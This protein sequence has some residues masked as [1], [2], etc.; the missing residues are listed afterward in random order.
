MIET[1]GVNNEDHVWLGID[2]GVTTGWALV[3]DDGKVLG[4][5]DLVPENIEFGLDKIVRGLHRTSRTITVVIERI[6]RTGGMGGLAR[7]M[8]E[9]LTAIHEVID[10]VYDLPVIQVAPGEWKQSRVAAQELGWERGVSQHQKDAAVMAR[11][12]ADK[13]QRRVSRG[14]R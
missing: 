12:V 2:P 8:E 7:K 6:P 4:T 5:G 9:V 14:V 1:Y 3:A 11:Y 13:E 10:E